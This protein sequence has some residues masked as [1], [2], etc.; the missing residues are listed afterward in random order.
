M[1]SLLAVTAR[2]GTTRASWKGT[3][4]QQQLCMSQTLSV[5]CFVRALERPSDT[6]MGTLSKLADA[7]EPASRDT[8]VVGVWGK[9]NTGIAGQIGDAQLPLLLRSAMCPAWFARSPDKL[10]CGWGVGGGEGLEHSG[11][12]EEEQQSRGSRGSSRG[13]SLE[14]QLAQHAH[15][16]ATHLTPLCGSAAAVAVAATGQEQQLCPSEG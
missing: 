11:R 16:H 7:C 1:T 10:R 4:Y 13:S 3:Q 12:D 2:S 6:Y 8:S 14:A 15:A 9:R 5:L